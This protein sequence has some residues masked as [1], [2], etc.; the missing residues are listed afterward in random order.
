MAGEGPS[1]PVG[2]RPT[3][4]DKLNRLFEAAHAK[5]ERAPTN[6]AVAEGV[7][8]LGTPISETF[9][10]YLRTGKRDN[11]S[12]KHLEGIARYFDVPAWYFF[13]DTASQQLYEE[14]NL[15]AAM[16]DNDVRTLALRSADMD[17]RMRRW[18]I[19][20]VSR[21]EEAQRPPE[22]P[23]DDRAAEPDDGSG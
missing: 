20:T 15:L 4:A 16:R 13:D 22:R 17:P 12:M 19:D 9:I 14:L 11:P 2:D 8:A 7:S 18:L 5:G 21:L 23:D 10:Y 3:L 6:K 1:E